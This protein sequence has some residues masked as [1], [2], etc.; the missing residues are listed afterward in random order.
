MSYY[1]LYADGEKTEHRTKGSSP[2]KALRELTEA[3]GYLLTEQRG[4]YGTASGGT[5][6][7]ALTEAYGRT[8]SPDART[9]RTLR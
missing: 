1:R 9:T 8:D 4:R 2:A 5:R 3:A 6:V 7:M